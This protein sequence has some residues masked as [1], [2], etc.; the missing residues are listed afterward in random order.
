MLVL[1]SAS[2][3]RREI[4]SRFVESFDVVP[5]SVEERCSGRPEEC[6]VKLAKLKAREVHKRVGGTVIGADTVVSIDGR[7]LGKPK[8]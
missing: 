3:R 6:A 5:S 7:I 1:A 8:S 4:L 2:P